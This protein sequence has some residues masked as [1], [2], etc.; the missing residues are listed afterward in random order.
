[1]LL[2]HSQDGNFIILHKINTLHIYSIIDNFVEINKKSRDNMQ[3]ITL[4]LLAAVFLFSS[5]SKESEET[6]LLNA[7]SKLEEAKKFEGE[8][9]PDDAKR[10]YTEAIEMYKT[11][12]AEYSASAKAPEVYSIIAKTYLDNLKDFENSIRFY[13][14]L[15]D[16]YPG[17]K[18]AKYG[19]FMVAFIYDEMLKNK[20]MAKDS[21]KKFLEKYPKDEDP[22]E[23]MSE[24]AKMMLQMLEENKSVEDII[25]NV[26][27]DT[28]KKK[29]V[30]PNVKL[31]KID[32]DDGEVNEDGTPK[33]INIPDE[34][35]HPK[36]KR[37]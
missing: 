25:K 11:F 30:D 27:Q 31:K 19:M 3:K 35:K 16:K 17:T 21:Y 10:T 18:E 12:L 13:K 32:G 20:E 2:P 28:T 9:K 29:E 34:E 23:Q 15:S 4:L 22:N 7:K 24:S 6:M 8:N 37:D 14:E 1:L 33:D 26:P 36:E 5:C